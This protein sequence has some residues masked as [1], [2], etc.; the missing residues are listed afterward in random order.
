MLVKNFEEKVM[1]KDKATLPCGFNTKTCVF[2]SPSDT[3]SFQSILEA[4]LAINVQNKQE[5]TT[6]NM[7]LTN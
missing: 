2:L 4:N 1:Q 3:V 7:Q 5:E 6:S